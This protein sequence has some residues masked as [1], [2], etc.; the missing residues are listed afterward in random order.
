MKDCYEN[1]GIRS[2]ERCWKSSRKKKKENELK[3]R[4]RGKNK[5]G[6]KKS[7]ESKKMLLQN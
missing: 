4:G 7:A 6:K 1:G 3:E 5:N 2:N